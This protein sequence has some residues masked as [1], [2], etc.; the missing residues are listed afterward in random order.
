MKQSY[1]RRRHLY[2]A[3]LIDLCVGKLSP[4]FF[5]FGGQQNNWLPSLYPIPVKPLANAYGYQTQFQTHQEV[6]ILVYQ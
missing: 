6:L 1:G 2:R 5:L 4:L 3:L